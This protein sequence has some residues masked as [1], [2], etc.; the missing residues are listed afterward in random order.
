MEEART[1]GAWGFGRGGGSFPDLF[2]FPPTPAIQGIH[3]AARSA[4]NSNQIRVAGFRRSIRRPSTCPMHAEQPLQAWPACSPFLLP[5]ST[6][7]DLL[8]KRFL[9]LPALPAGQRTRSMAERLGHG[10]HTLRAWLSG[11]FLQTLPELV[12]PL[13]GHSLGFTSVRSV[14]MMLGF[15]SSDVG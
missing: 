4:P 6:P 8:V 15:M 14:V 9:F 12:T 11:T 5:L 7:A 1:E 10:A 2:P 3:P 13:K